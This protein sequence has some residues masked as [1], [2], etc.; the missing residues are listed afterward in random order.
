MI[1]ILSAGPN[2]PT[3][4]GV[5]PTDTEMDYEEQIRG[6][7]RIRNTVINSIATRRVVCYKQHIYDDIRLEMS[8]YIGLTLAVRDASVHTEVKPFYDEVAIQI[9]DDDSKYIVSQCMYH[10]AHVYIRRLPF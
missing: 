6:I 10:Y 9:V 4:L 2:S 5:Y 8:E 7:N 3:F 1:K